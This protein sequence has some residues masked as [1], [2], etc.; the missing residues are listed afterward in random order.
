[1]DIFYLLAAQSVILF[2]VS[3]TKHPPKILTRNNG[4]KYVQCFPC[5]SILFSLHLLLQEAPFSNWS[6]WSLADMSEANWGL[7]SN[8]SIL[9]FYPSI[10]KW[11][12]CLEVSL[13]GGSL[14]NP[15]SR[16]CNSPRTLQPSFWLCDAVDSSIN[17]WKKNSYST[18]SWSFFKVV[19]NHTDLQILQGD[20]PQWLHESIC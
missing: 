16:H 11:M 20:F 18:M 5:V 4:D 2:P 8:L 10:P 6:H 13:L 1:M 15:R 17:T 12:S 3:H 9:S 14:S 19:G 7:H